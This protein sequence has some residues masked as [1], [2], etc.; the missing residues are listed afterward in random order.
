MITVQNPTVVKCGHKLHQDKQPNNN[1][2]ACWEAYFHTQ[3]DLNVLVGDLRSLGTQGFIAKYGTKMFKNFRGF[4]ASEMLKRAQQQPENP[5]VLSVDNERVE[6]QG[7][8]IPLEGAN[9]ISESREEGTGQE[10]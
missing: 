1:C 3:A 8:T 2:V 5:T 7:S 4:V 6:I 10:G 9:A